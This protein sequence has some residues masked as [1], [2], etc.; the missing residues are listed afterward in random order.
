MIVSTQHTRAH[1]APARRIRDWVEDEAP[2]EEIP[3]RILARDNRG[4]YEL[5]FPVL[6]RDDWW[7][8]DDTREELADGVDVVAWAFWSE[9]EASR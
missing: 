3:L 4:T 6:R 5:P 1:T 8:N 9:R 7:V 2:P